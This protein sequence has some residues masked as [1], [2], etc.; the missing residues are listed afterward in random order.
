MKNKNKLLLVGTAMVPTI[1]LCAPT[2]GTVVSGGISIQQDG[3]TTNIF[4][5]TQQAI[6]NW[7]GFNIGSNEIVNFIQPSSSSIALNR[8]ISGNPTTILGQLNANGVVILVNPRGI[9]FTQSA[10]LDVAGLVATTL[11]VG[12]QDFLSGKLQFSRSG[13]LAGS[14]I[15]EG[16]LTATDNGFIVLAGDYVE[17]TGIVTANLG[18][19]GLAA[20]SEITLD[21]QGDGL[22]SFV[23]DGEAVSDLAGVKNSGDLI[24]QGG[25]VVMTANVASELISTSVS[26]LGLVRAQSIAEHEGEIYLLGNDADVIQTGTLDVSSNDA[27]V[28]GGNIDILGR[29]IAVVGNAVMSANGLNGGEIHIGGDFQG[30]GDRQ[31]AEKTIIGRHVVI[32]ANGVGE[33]DG[34]KV[35]IWSDLFTQYDGLI[36][37]KGGSTSGNGGFVEVSGKENLGFSGFVDVSALNGINGTILLDPA[38]IVISNAAIAGKTPLDGDIGNLGGIILFS[39]FVGDTTNILTGTIA[40]L[41]VGGTVVLQAD[42]NITFDSGASIFVSSGSGSLILES[43]SVDINVSSGSIFIGDA[44]GAKQPLLVSADA[45]TFSDG[46]SGIDFI[47]SPAISGANADPNLDPNALPPQDEIF[48]DPIIDPNLADGGGFDPYA[49][50]PPDGDATQPPPPGGEPTDQP[51]LDASG[52]PI[53]APLDADGNPVEPAI[54]PEG[55]LVGPDGNL[56]LDENGEPIQGEVD[57]EGNLVGPDGEPLKDPSEPPLDENGNPVEE[58]SEEQLVADEKEEEAQPLNEQPLIG[59]DGEKDLLAC[60]P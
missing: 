10:T 34:G 53:Q 29:N 28:D 41:L 17:N 30:T 52:D 4:Q 3:Q 23:I 58:G 59:I 22:V 21:L 35:I 16:E 38:E 47:L 33:G 13:E 48:Q 25:R 5:S 9:L 6:I 57:A 40:S 11:D 46:I 37:A 44:V 24:A 2:G 8:V 51:L 56:V 54:D 1:G 32:S 26:N 55:N 49:P 31:R 43:L 7:D 27:G 39:D 42:N 19:V 60:S 14:V 20:A 50:P 36:S 15:N 12:N 18:Q 45:F